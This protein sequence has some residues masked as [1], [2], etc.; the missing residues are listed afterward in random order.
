[1]V[2]QMGFSNV[3]CCSEDVR[4]PVDISAVRMDEIGINVGVGLFNHLSRLV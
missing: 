1:M 3:Y 4:R 2:Y